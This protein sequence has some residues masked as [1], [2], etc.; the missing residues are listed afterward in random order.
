M[1]RAQMVRKKPGLI[2]RHHAFE[3]S[4]A[5]DDLAHDAPDYLIVALH[6]LNP[7]TAHAPIQQARLF[8]IARAVWRLVSLVVVAANEISVSLGNADFVCDQPYPRSRH[9]A[10]QARSSIVADPAGDGR[11]LRRVES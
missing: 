1:T 2:I 3:N 9:G 5:G 11:D 4:S 10:W 6:F 7:F 8:R